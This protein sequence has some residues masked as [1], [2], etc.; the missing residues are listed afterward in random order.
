MMHEYKQPKYITLTNYFM[1]LPLAFLFIN[2]L[3]TH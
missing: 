1:N 3:I 2:N